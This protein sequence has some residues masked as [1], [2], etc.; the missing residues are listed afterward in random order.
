MPGD[1]DNKIIKISLQDLKALERLAVV[2]SGHDILVKDYQATR[3]H[4]DENIGKM[5]ELLRAF[6]K[7]VAD[8]SD[9][10]ETKIHADLEKHYA[11]DADVKALR[12]ELKNEIGKI[13]NRFKW[14]TGLIVMF[15]GAVQF[16]MTMYF[17]T[18]QIQ[19]LTVLG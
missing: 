7:Q 18:L 5:F 11:T 14:T 13:G 2:E 4:T 9:D 17:L 1:D 19:K 6:P 16:F 10:L 15:A 3:N 12:V 8:C